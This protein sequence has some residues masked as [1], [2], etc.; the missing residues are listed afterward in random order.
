MVVRF[1]IVPFVV[2]LSVNHAATVGLQDVAVF[3][4][5]TKRGY[6]NTLEVVEM[7]VL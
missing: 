1:A 2:N 5:L 4:M 7:S 3:L 6:T